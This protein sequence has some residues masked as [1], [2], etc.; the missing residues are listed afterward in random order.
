MKR[1]EKRR[2]GIAPSL[3]HRMRFAVCVLQQHRRVAHANAHRSSRRVNILTSP[4]PR[5]RPSRRGFPFSGPCLRT[6]PGHSGGAARVLH[7]LPGPATPYLRLFKHIAPPLSNPC[8]GHWRGFYF[9]FPRVKMTAQFRSRP[10]GSAQALQEGRGCKSPAAST[11]VSDD[12][13]TSRHCPGR[14][15]EREGVLEEESQARRPAHAPQQ[16]LPGQGSGGFFPGSLRSRA[17]GPRPW[18]AGPFCRALRAYFLRRGV[19]VEGGT[20]A[21]AFFRLRL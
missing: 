16:E 1:R 5:P 4:P 15:P 17:E 19:T 10:C 21:S 7:P 20:A 2:H 3:L 18:R 13:R 9:S 6:R 11:T 8:G 14:T 12:E